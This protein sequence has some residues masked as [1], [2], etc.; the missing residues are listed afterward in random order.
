MHVAFL[1]FGLIAGAIAQ[2]LK[3]D[4]GSADRTIAAWSPSGDG[5]RRAHEEGIVDLVAASPPA[6]LADAD[7][8][9]LAGPAT[10]CLTLLDRSAGE[11]RGAMPPEAVVTDV[12]S[13][14]VAL[15]SRADALGIRFVGGHPMAGL[16]SSGYLTGTADL[17]V[18]RPWVIS[19][20]S[21]AEP[22]DIDQVVALATACSATVVFLDAATHDRAVAAISHLPLIV[23]AAMVGSVSGPGALGGEADDV[24]PVAARLAAGGWRDGTR[25]ARGDPAM[26]AAIAATNPVE[27]AA[28]IRS[29]RD[30]LDRWLADLERAGGPDEAAMRDRLAAARAMLEA[31]Q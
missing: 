27:L 15:V 1:G 7:L 20:G 26:G 12:A 10:A 19:P 21:V 8:V 11:W 25:V 18:G 5:P 29:M 2:A 4:P 16:E 31:G 14:K 6:A 30:E 24:W 28:R 13:T 9:V 3:S 23:A 22:A 17:F